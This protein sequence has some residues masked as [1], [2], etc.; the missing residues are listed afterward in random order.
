MLARALPTEIRSL[1]VSFPSV[2]TRTAMA[3]AV[4]V[5]TYGGPERR[6]EPNRLSPNPVWVKQRL[7]ARLGLG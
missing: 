5:A 1:A 7:V 3:R 6:R 2:G 4:V